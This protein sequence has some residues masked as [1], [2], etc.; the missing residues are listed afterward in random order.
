MEFRRGPEAPPTEEVTLGI[1]ATVFYQSP[2]DGKWHR[3]DR[4][5]T[6]GKREGRQAAY[7]IYES[8]IGTMWTDEE[9]DKNLSYLPGP[10][11]RTT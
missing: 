11:S 7:V 3:T 5:F 4:T 8:L 2:L 10:N 6:V 1:V 9:V